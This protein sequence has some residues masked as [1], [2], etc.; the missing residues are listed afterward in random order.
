MKRIT[1]SEALKLFD[2][3]SKTLGSCRQVEYK[4][5]KKC[6]CKCHCK[7]RQPNK[8]VETKTC[9]DY[10]IDAIK[11]LADKEAR[12]CGKPIFIAWPYSY[13]SRRFEIDE[14]CDSS[15]TT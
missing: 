8:V 2:K 3:Y 5:Y 6:N 15:G 12:D 10:A 14:Y 9:M 11:Y 4:N 13:C 1:Q 7:C